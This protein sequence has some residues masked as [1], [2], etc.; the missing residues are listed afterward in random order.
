MRSAPFLW[1]YLRRQSKMTRA[2]DFRT[3]DAAMFLLCAISVVRHF[4]GSGACVMSKPSVGAGEAIVAPIHDSLCRRIRITE[5]RL[6]LARDLEIVGRSRPD[7]ISVIPRGLEDLPSYRRLAEDGLAHATMRY[8]GGGVIVL[9]AA[10]R[11]WR[12]PKLKRRLLCEARRETHRPQSRSCHGAGVVAHFGLPSA[13]RRLLGP[14]QSGRSPDWASKPLMRTSA[15]QAPI[16]PMIDAPT[17]AAHCDGAT[18]RSR[19]ESSLQLLPE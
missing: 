4:G 17:G 18:S 3:D 1:R 9:A 5:E 19:K 16:A 12:R 13:S 14:A 8:A 11:I 2:V 15:L 7:V 10:G 6:R